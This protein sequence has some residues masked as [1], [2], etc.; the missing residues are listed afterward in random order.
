MML[1]AGAVL[2]LGTIA[3]YIVSWLTSS[4]MSTKAKQLVA[5]AVSVVLAVIV[6]STMGVFGL[7]FTAGFTGFVESFVVAL[8]ALFTVQQ[9]VYNLVFRNTELALDTLLNRG[10]GKH[11]P[12]VDAEELSDELDDERQLQL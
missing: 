3:P 12:P 10:V 9:L 5:F 11:I 1:S 8:P 6:A 2:V 7:V 4:A